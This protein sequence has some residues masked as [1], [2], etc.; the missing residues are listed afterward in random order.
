MSFATEKKVWYKR[1]KEA[2]PERPKFILLK[3]QNT[4]VLEKKGQSILTHADQFRARFESE[5]VEMSKEEYKETKEEENE[6]EQNMEESGNDIKDLEDEDRPRSPLKRTGEEQKWEW[7]TP[8][9]VVRRPNKG[10]KP[11]RFRKL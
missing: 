6:T 9:R 8:S 5:D 7:R 3:G 2:E 1:N 4:A 11:R 10:V